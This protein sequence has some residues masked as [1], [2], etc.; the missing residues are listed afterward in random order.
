[1]KKLLLSIIIIIFSTFLF[2]CSKDDTVSNSIN[3][4]GGQIYRYQV[5][6]INVGSTSLTNNVYTGTLAGTSV[7]LTKVADHELVFYVPETTP[8]GATELHINSLNNAKINYEIKDVVLT[9]SVDETLTPLETNFENYGNQLSTA[10]QDIPFVQNHSTMMSYYNGLSIEEKSEVAKFYK[11]NETIIDAVYNTN[12]STIQG[13]NIDMQENRALVLRFKAALAVGMIGSAV[14]VAE[15]SNIIRP[16]AIGVAIAG[17]SAAVDYHF[18]LIDRNINI[19]EMKINALIGTNNR[20]T[21]SQLSLTENVATTLPFNVNVRPIQET[22]SNSQQEYM[23]LYFATKNRLNELISN[24]NEAIL[25]VNNAI[26]FVSF[27]TL[28]LAQVSSS[29]NPVTAD[30]TSQIMQKINFN[31]S[32]SN[33]SL[34][35]ATLQNNG[36]LNLKVKFVGNP[37]ATSISSTLN[38]TYNDDF[39]SFSGSFPIEVNIDTSTFLVGNWNLIEYNGIVPN[40]NNIIYNS[41]QNCPTNPTPED[42]YG[43]VSF[44]GSAS[45]TTTTFSCPVTRNQIAKYCLTNDCLPNL[46]F[47]QNLPNSG[48]YESNGNYQ[49]N[50]TSNTGGSTDTTITVIN[51]NTI[52]INYNGILK[53]YSRQ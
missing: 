51:Q 3:E 49:F 25:W 1:M 27:D 14:A 36:Q 7:Q 11:V 50:V 39:S 45:F 35:T 23:K 6:T 22:D 34:E 48:T 31:I 24:I 8:L 43:G 17:I 19:I 28:P 4:N 47:T 53:K 29:A 32:H 26:P 30:V 5:V 21:N 46:C 52:S 38:Y 37:T 40:Q 33:L 41:L 9:Q 13:R 12:Y 44:S 16:I 15:P 2:S 20:N 18:E 10:S 42:W